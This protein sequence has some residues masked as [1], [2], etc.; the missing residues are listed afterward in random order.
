VLAPLLCG[1]TLNEGII[2]ASPDH[3]DGLLFQIAGFHD[4]LTRQLLLN[5]CCCFGR[6]HLLPKEEVHYPQI[7]RQREYPTSCV[8]PHFVLVLVELGE[9]VHILPHVLPVSM[10]NV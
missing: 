6:C 7:D 2:Q 4:D 1:V 5:E 3:L 9:P 10:E 8:S